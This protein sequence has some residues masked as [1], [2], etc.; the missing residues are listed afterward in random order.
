[1][2]RLSPDNEPCFFGVDEFFASPGSWREVVLS[3]YNQLRMSPGNEN[4]VTC[5]GAFNK[6]EQKTLL[7]LV[8]G[9][10]FDG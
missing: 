10:G 7:I 1:M 4:V 3:W 9:L 6:R 5:H 8:D 2:S